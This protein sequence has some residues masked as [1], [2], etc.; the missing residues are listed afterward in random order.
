MKVRGRLRTGAKW[1]EDGAAAVNTE[2]LQLVNRQSQS[3]QKLNRHC[4]D[5]VVGQELEDLRDQLMEKQEEW[6]EERAVGS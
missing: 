5:K 4:R 6:A 3:L 2:Q 1:K